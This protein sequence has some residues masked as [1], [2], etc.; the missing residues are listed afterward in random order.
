MKGKTLFALLG[1]MAIAL[2][3]VHLLVGPVAVHAAD[4]SALF[5]GEDTTGSIVLREVRLPRVLTAS[6]A[7][8]GLAISG[9]LMQTWFHNPLA[10]PSVLGVTSGASMGVALAVLG[11]WTWGWWGITF[12]ALLG[13]L[14][15]LGLLLL[16]AM[17][18]RG[19]AGLLIFG[20]MLSYTL[21]ALIAVFQAE[22]RNDA[23]Q[24]FVFWGMGTFGQTPL[25]I[26]GV[27]WL[28][29]IGV[30]VWSWRNHRQLDMWTLGPV[31]AQSMGVHPT[32]FQ[33]FLVAASGLLTGSITA[34]C[35]P[36]AFL[37]LATPHAVRMLTSER[38][39]AALVP[40]SAIMGMTLALFADLGVRAPWTD[41]SGWPLNAV[42]SLLGGPLVVWVLF[43]KTWDR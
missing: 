33:W 37:G 32:Q 13:S 20:L 15:V 16:V 12:M 8:F 7:G 36:V 24:Q 41:V 6:A 34:L 17:R 5:S 40:L 3:A 25:K 43:R 35:G 22:A 1:F 19:T 11:G 29:T 9:L 30:G 14:A 28:L 39:H 42:L 4:W 21:G 27:L 10:G 26:S 31:T 18:F 2:A 23:L 38:R